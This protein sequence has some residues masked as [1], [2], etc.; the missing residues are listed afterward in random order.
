VTK[1]IAAGFWRKLLTRPL[2]NAER[3]CIVLRQSPD[4]R[5]TPYPDLIEGSRAFCRMIAGPT[6]LSENFISDVVQVWDRTFAMPFFHVRAAMKDI[7]AENLATV[8]HATLA[9]IASAQAGTA[10]G[11]ALLYLFVDDDDWLHPDLHEQIKPY[12][13]DDNDGYIFGN[14][15][16][17]SHVELRRVEDGCYT[18]N[19]AVS[20]RYLRRQNGNFDGVVQHWGA[21]DVFHQ[22]NFHFVHVP[23]YLSATNKH[24]ASTMKLKDGLQESQLC[25]ATLTRLV[26]KFVDETENLTC[27]REAEWIAPYTK[28][29][30]NVFAKLLLGSCSP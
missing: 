22:P 10:T 21:N 23:L 25:A 14:I 17:V 29:V 9:S 20:G 26:E 28:K 30:R 11:T 19:Y 5:N 12:L 2:V 16:C 4:W 7:A 24:P 27:P 1:F 18:N 8:R 15:L 3:L 13:N 6:G